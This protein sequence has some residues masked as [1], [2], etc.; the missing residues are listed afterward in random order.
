MSHA[1]NIPLR[2]FTSALQAVAALWEDGY[3]K[4]DT[5]S[6]R[7]GFTACLEIRELHFSQKTAAFFR[8]FLPLREQM[9]VLLAESY[10]RYFKLGLAHARQTGGDPDKW[11]RSQLQLAIGAALEW[12]RDWYILACEG[13]NQ[14]VRRTASVD[15]VPG[16]TVSLSIPTTVPP[17]S[18]PTSWRAPAW[19]FVISAPLVGVGPLKQHHV[20]NMDSLE[21]LGEA[22]TRLLLK[23]ARRVF[24][25]KL[26][27]AIETVRNEEIAA[28]GAIPA[29]SLGEQT[30]KEHKR[31]GSKHLARGMDGLG[32]KKIDLSRYT[33]N[34]TERQ[35]LA[36]SLKY[37]YDLGL[38]EIAS[39]MGLDRKTAYEHIEAAERKI[40]Q[41]H[42]REKWKSVR[43]QG[44]G[45]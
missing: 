11:A 40:K 44:T 18:P 38:T 33:Q 3:A 19:L 29:D 22:H 39:R 25:W 27:A 5:L 26:G 31:K 8:C 32:P 28:A 12:I 23:G 14:R 37:E 30:G 7:E 4:L 42:S 17:F 34:L 6:D 24:L 1:N 21:K 36:F 41:T 15:F 43:V 35:E 9:V 16:Q 20:P 45:E 10:R 13:E 2:A